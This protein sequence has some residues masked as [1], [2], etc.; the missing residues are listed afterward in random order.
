MSP[1]LEGRQ[2]KLLSSGAKLT[3]IKSVLLVMLVYYFSLLDPLDVTVDAL[4]KIVANFF[5]NDN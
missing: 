5:W 1:K 3:L 4:H 2:G